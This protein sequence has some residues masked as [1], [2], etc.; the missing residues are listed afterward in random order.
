MPSHSNYF[1]KYCFFLYTVLSQICII[2]FW[3]NIKMPVNNLINLRKTNTV[4]LLWSTLTVR[5]LL[6][7]CCDDGV[8]T[9]MC[10]LFVYLLY[11]NIP[12]WLYSSM[13]GIVACI[14]PVTTACSYLLFQTAL[15]IPSISLLFQFKY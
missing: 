4:Q 7:C 1:F 3:K 15:R 10:H 13:P 9:K 14:L 2:S 5:R 6:F 8:M 11:Y 12:D